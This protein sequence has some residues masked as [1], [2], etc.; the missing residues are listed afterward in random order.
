MALFREL[1]TSSGQI[2]QSA[3]DA[4]S[5][6]RCLGRRSP[7]AL[8][9]GALFLCGCAGSHKRIENAMQTPPVSRTPLAVEP[10]TLGCPDVL[11]VS[12][13]G[14]TDAPHRCAVGV[15]GRIEVGNLGRV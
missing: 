5:G 7:W 12:L 8:V 2:M 11:E 9:L 14:Q 1:A 6:G 13:I 10:Y 15:D 4:A 3:E